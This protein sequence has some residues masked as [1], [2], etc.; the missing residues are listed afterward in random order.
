MHMTEEWMLQGTAPAVV[1]SEIISGISFFL[2]TNGPPF[3]CV[4]QVLWSRRKSVLMSYLCFV[5]PHMS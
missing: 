2:V 1:F 3:S 4:G 5:Y